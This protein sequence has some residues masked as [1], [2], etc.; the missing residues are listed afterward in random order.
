MDNAGQVVSRDR[1]MAGLYGWDVDEIDSNTIDVH[2][3]HLRRKLGKEF[4]RTVRGVGFIVGESA[5]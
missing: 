4:V 2:I 1:L 5:A 3:F